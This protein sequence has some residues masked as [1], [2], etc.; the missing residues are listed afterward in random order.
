MDVGSE[1]V[2]PDRSVRDLFSTSEIPGDTTHDGS[3]DGEREN[4]GVGVRQVLKAEI[5]AFYS[6]K[7]AKYDSKEQIAGN[8]GRWKR[9]DSD[10][11]TTKQLRPPSISK[12]PT[13]PADS[14]AHNE[15]EFDRNWH[16]TRQ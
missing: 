9:Q 3:E 11:A 2:W 1:Q 14:V 15:R 7:I 16:R 12:N 5:L 4:G 8:S 6:E 10:K 13:L